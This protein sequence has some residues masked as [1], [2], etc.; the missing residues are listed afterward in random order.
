VLGPLALVGIGIAHGQLMGLGGLLGIAGM[1]VVTVP[2]AQTAR[3]SW[4]VRL[5]G[6]LLIIPGMMVASEFLLFEIRT[7]RDMSDVLFAVFVC[8][9]PM[10]VALHRLY[11]FWH[12]P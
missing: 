7:G 9:L 3:R 11:I 4:T 5:T 8:V 6:T 12:R 1:W 2:L 10:T